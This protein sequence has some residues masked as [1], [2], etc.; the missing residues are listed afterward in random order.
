M[1]LRQP[2][3]GAA[4]QAASAATT[5]VD[6][7]AG[8]VTGRVTYDGPALPNPSIK[9][10]SDPR[11]ARASQR[12]GVEAVLVNNGGLDN[13]FVYVKDGLS[14]YAFDT[15]TGTGIR[16][17]QKV[18]LH[19]A[20]V[21]LR[22]GQPLVI[23][24]GDQT[25]HT[26]HAMGQANQEFNLSQPLQGIS[27]TKTFTAPEVMVHS[28]A[29]STPGWRLRRGRQPPYFA[30][31][32]NG[33]GF[34]LKGCRRGPIPSPR[35]TRSSAPRA[36]RHPRREGI[37]TGKLRV[38]GHHPVIWLH[39]FIKLCRRLHAAADSR[40]RDGHQHR[41]RAGGAGLAQHLRP[42]HVRVPDREDGR[43]HLLRA[44][45][46]DDRQHGGLPGPSS[47]RPGPGGSSRDAGC[48]GSA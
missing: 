42:L 45:P 26:V 10:D 17:D 43:R 36:A 8:N 21:R 22:A 27:H 13:V 16:L 35:G 41:F 25:L 9:L 33:G 15:P 20:R 1:R 30:V 28:S 44:R 2:A 39:R 38:Q 12:D 19:A 4:P 32:A 18:P 46:P 37:E 40:G 48:G 31:S 47:S 14:D 5:R 24:N 23:A 6:A 7:T 11:G 29:T 34:E 3:R